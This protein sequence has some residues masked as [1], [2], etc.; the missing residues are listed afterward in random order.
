MSNIYLDFAL[1]LTR[2]LAERH[3]VLVFAGG[4]L[5]PGLQSLLVPVHLRL[6]LLQLLGL[7]EDVVLNTQQTAH[8]VRSLPFK[9]PL[10]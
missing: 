4:L 1:I 7:S 9:S 3:G 5:K 6:H 8:N 2:V 10:G